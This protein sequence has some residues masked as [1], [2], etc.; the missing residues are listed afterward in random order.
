MCIVNKTCHIC[1]LK[2]RI[3][4][5]LVSVCSALHFFRITLRLNVILVEILRAFAKQVRKMVC[6]VVGL[7]FIIKKY[8]WWHLS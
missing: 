4:G 7:K 6:L 8:G 5:K 2:K 1:A 3:L